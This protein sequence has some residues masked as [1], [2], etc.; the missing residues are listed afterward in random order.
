MEL[1]HASYEIC[2]KVYQ[3]RYHLSTSLKQYLENHTL[4]PDNRKLLKKVCVSFFRHQLAIFNIID[5]AFQAIRNNDRY[6]IGVALAAYIFTSGISSDEILTE[7]S[8]LFKTNKSLVSYDLVEKLFENKAKYKTL[9][10]TNV[11]KDSA[12]YVSLENN[13]PSWLV[14]MWSKHYGKIISTKLAEHTRKAPTLSMRVNK[15]K[16]TQK[17]I[18]DNGE[19][20][21]VHG[22]SLSGTD[23]TF[24]PDK[25][26]ATSKFVEDGYLIPISNGLNHLVN[27]LRIKTEDVLVI[28][29]ANTNIGFALA[30]QAANRAY[31]RVYYEDDAERLKAKIMSQKYGFEKME[32]AAGTLQVLETYVTREKD[33]VVVAPTST[34]FNAICAIPDFFMHLDQRELDEII[35]AEMDALEEGAR[36]VIDGG[37]L[38]YT[39]ETCNN[40]EG[41]LL[42]KSFLNFHPEYKLLEERQSLEL[43]RR[44]TDYYF[45][46]LRKQG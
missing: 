10:P 31:V 19:R 41:R 36:Y 20:H 18:I 28:D 44:K 38:V 26:M 46:I 35:L 34:N 4:N 21:Y 42:I 45:A 17:Y 12:K 7:L 3:K 8:D 33:V 5:Y 2:Y 30:E 1:I 29:Y 23:V 40:K 22:L 15:L 37:T 9:V 24:K 16:T 43:D 27:K 39:V 25:E 13:I 14:T 11:A 32:F 6:M